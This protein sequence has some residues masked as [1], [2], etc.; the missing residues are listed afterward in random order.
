MRQPKIE[1]CHACKRLKSD[2]SVPWKVEQV[3]TSSPAQM[4]QALNVDLELC[5]GELDKSLKGSNQR[6]KVF[7][8]HQEEREHEIFVA[9][10]VFPWHSAY[11]RFM[12]E[13]V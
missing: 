4:G 3:T 6:L 2:L 7:K 13:R 12:A 5:I 1:T 11:D 9:C 8:K 10:K